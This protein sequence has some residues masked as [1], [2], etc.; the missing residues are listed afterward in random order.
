MRD[1]H[2]QGI[3]KCNGCG[4][5]FKWGHVDYGMPV[6]YLY[7]PTCQQKKAVGWQNPNDA[8]WT[9]N[10]CGNHYYLPGYSRQQKSHNNRLQFYDCWNGY[11]DPDDFPTDGYDIGDG[12]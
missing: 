1:Y 4:Y 11:S 7:C 10:R 6:K 2:W 9:C 5:V 3:H 12:Y 8:E